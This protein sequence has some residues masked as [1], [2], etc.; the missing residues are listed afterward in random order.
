MH[1][2]AGNLKR[3]TMK[4]ILPIGLI[5]LFAACKQN[6]SLEV[7]QNIVPADTSSL[8]TS[9]ASTDAGKFVQATPVAPAPA[10]EK[11]RV[12]YVDRP[13][14]KEVK[15]EP[16]PVEQKQARQSGTVSTPPS[17]SAT[18]PVSTAKDSSSTAGAGSKSGP[19]AGSGGSS[20][21]ETT[22]T[23][24]APAKEVKKKGI[25]TAAKGAVIGG[26]GGAVVGAV[27]SKN[28]VKGAVI[29]GVV[30]A[31]GGYIFGRSKD[32]QSGRVDAQN[33][34]VSSGY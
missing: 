33:I 25:S 1:I 9:N 14:I 10:Q 29:G 12:V 26:V 31:V 32:K 23:T 19:V 34:L 3:Y 20:G 6:K 17:T 15:T 11:V 16:K 4:K 7:K 27:L 18:P 24:T 28:K 5:V 8:Y 2:S 13:V 21:K 22:T 30:G